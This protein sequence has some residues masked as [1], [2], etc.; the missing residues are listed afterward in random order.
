MTIDIRLSD[1]LARTVEE[2]NCWLWT[3]HATRGTVPQWHVDGK[4]RSARRVVYEAKTGAPVPD[5]LLIFPKCGN[6]LCVHPDCLVARHESWQPTKGR[7]IAADH[8]ARIAAGKRA[9]SNLTMDIVRTIRASDEPGP[10]LEA[11]YGLC[12]GKA[13]RIRANRCWVDTA[14]PFAGLG[15]R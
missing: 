14:S 3:G 15:A 11:R 12:A 2:G 4:V 9:A 1:L 5:T 8:R 7:A 6:A 10:V 13:S